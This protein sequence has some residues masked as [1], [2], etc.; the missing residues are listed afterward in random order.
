MWTQWFKKLNNHYFLQVSSKLC[1]FAT[2]KYS[3]KLSSSWAALLRLQELA[4]NT[5]HA[6]RYWNHCWLYITINPDK[7]FEEHIYSKYNKHLAKT[8]FS[9]LLTFQ[10]PHI[11]I[12]V[13]DI[14][15]KTILFRYETDVH[16]IKMSTIWLQF[17]RK[18]TVQI[19]WDNVSHWHIRNWSPH[20]H[21]MKKVE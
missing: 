5:Y 1:F 20:V 9:I 6:S 7:D 13:L 21:G 15:K 8:E 17:K 16:F 11:F 12:Y 10:H 4:I 2:C 3:S 19:I 18:S 14:Y